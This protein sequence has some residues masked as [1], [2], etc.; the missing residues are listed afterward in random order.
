MSAP[1][2]PSPDDG[3]AITEEW[4]ISIGFTPPREYR[5]FAC[6]QTIDVHDSLHYPEGVHRIIV[7]TLGDVDDGHPHR[8][9]EWYVSLQ[10]NDHINCELIDKSDPDDFDISG[11]VNTIKSAHTRGDIRQICYWLGAELVG[12]GEGNAQ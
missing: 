12:N 11:E 2:I 4:L 3:E 6:V 5:D 7:N 8:G 9:I 10:A 1:Y